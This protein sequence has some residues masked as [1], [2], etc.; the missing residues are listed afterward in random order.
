MEG[1]GQGWLQW[2]GNKSS[3]SA[4]Y[5]IRSTVYTFAL[6]RLFLESWEYILR[7]SNHLCLRPLNA[8]TMSSK[9]AILW[10]HLH[11]GSPPPPYKLFFSRCWLRSHHMVLN[12]NISTPYSSWCHFPSLASSSC[13]SF[14][15]RVTT[16]MLPVIQMKYETL[17]KTI[18]I[19][20]AF[21]SNNV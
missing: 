2:I 19:G 20:L 11:M 16:F 14:L 3:A 5:D 8:P 4:L 13:T 21:M 7:V 1:L 15:R 18:T 9:N 17:S 12:V 10:D 6:P